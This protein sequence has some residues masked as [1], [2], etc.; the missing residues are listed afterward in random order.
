M[1]QRTNASDAKFMSKRSISYKS[2]RS[3]SLRASVAMKHNFSKGTR[4]ERLLADA[5]EEA[6]L[7]FRKNADDL[8][9]KP[10][11]AFLRQRVAVFCDGDFWHGKGW[12]CRKKKLALGSNP[13]YWQ[14]K[15]ATNMRRDKEQTKKLQELGW[16]VLRFWESAVLRDLDFC[17]GK[18]LATVDQD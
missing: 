15:I 13:R 3:S 7:Q 4:C 2:F 12:R 11:L 18:I 9:G 6:G 1:V 16:I 8:P 14:V 10:D 5:V 17:V